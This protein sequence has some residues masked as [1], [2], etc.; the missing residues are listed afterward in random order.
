MSATPETTAAI[1]AANG[2]WTFDLKEKMQRLE[3]E[4]NRLAEQLTVVGADL[5][6]KDVV[7]REIKVL[8]EGL[9]KY[10]PKGTSQRTARAILAALAPVLPGV[11]AP[12]LMDPTT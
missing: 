1:V 4:R 8:A 11:E 3:E 9:H 6:N 7:L 12:P 10:G 2:A 5:L